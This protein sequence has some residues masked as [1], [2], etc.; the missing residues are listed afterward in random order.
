M[1][2][3]K[4]KLKYQI[5]VSFFLALFCLFFNPAITSLKLI[6]F[7]PFIVISFYNY[8]LIG[9][10]WLSILCGFFSDILASGSFGVI[11]MSYLLCS[12][13]LYRAKRFF[14]DKPVNLSIFTS[15]YSVIFS[16]FNLLFLFIFDKAV[17]ISLKWV[18]SDLIVMPFFDGIYAFFWFSLPF[19]VIEKIKRTNIK[20][21]W[22]HFKIKIFRHSR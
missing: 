11:T 2:Q 22:M 14:N 8:S 4:N 7:A 1:A 18:L 20:N 15:L 13:V 19:L 9:T 3:K 12:F 10:L 5:Y 17:I 21:L 16:I 6:Y